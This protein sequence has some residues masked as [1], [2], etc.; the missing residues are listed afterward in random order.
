[1]QLALRERLPKTW[2]CSALDHQ[3]NA[4]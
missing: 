4:H 1:V 3:H 2:R